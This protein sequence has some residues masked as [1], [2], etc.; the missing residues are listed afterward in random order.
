[1]KKMAVPEQPDQQVSNPKTTPSQL[2]PTTSQT[3]VLSNEIQ[4]LKGNNWA[5]WKWQLQNVLDSKGLTDVLTG[6][7]GR[8][9]PREVVTRQ[10]I[11]SS[12]DQTLICK[13]IHCQTAQQI[14][15]C[16]RGIYENRTSFA[17]TDLIGRMNSYRMNTLDEVENGVSEIQ[18]ISCQIKALGGTVDDN[19]IE[20]AILRALPK[21]FA[22]F[23]TSWTFLDADKRSLENL[24]A[25]IMRTVC[26]LRA[27]EQS[28]SKDKALAVRQFK[29]KGKNKFKETSNQSD[30]SKKSETFCRYCKKTNH[31]IKDCRKLAK[32]KAAED[33]A[34]STSE[35]TES[36]NNQD[37]ESPN[38]KPP[39]PEDASSARVAYGHVATI[40]EA[41]QCHNATTSN[42][43]FVK[44]SWIADS[45]ASFHM[46]SHIE[47]IVDYRE[48]KN[49]I[50][51]F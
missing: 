47:W 31:V 9:T 29:G 16:L 3:A 46:T 1:M 49:K 21:S 40:G 2:V 48:F 20:S 13:V 26:L 18:S 11:S 33:K 45:G 43:E 30:P 22:S 15:T 32:K 8:G 5:T 12:L 35:Q 28:E 37:K 39:K 25:H 36:S 14:W 34:S 6:D 51:V 10:I 42:P 19:T 27:T 41:I 44:T 38:E 17:L 24:H 7:E 4:R 50:W 23:L